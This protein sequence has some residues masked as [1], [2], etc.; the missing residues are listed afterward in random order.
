[1]FLGG[2]DNDFQCPIC[3]DNFTADRSQ[4]VVQLKPCDHLIHK[5]CL[6]DYYQAAKNNKECPLCR[7]TIYDAVPFP[8]KNKKIHEPPQERHKTQEEKQER[9]AY[10]KKVAAM[11]DKIKAQQQIPVDYSADLAALIENY[12]EQ[13]HL[14]HDQLIPIEALALL[15]QRALDGLNNDSRDVIENVN[16]NIKRRR[17]KSF[18]IC[19]RYACYKLGVHSPTSTS[20]VRQNGGGS[21]VFRSNQNVQAATALLINS[22]S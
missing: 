8:P 10:Q 5:A 15:E 22:R 9:E 2:A 19:R 17:F 21:L 6:L 14:S 3:Q 12:R 1:M 16:E 4:P 11:Q 7:R 18:R 13:H 20:S